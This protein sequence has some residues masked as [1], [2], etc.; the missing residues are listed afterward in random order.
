MAMI[1]SLV[2]SNGGISAWLAVAA[3]RE[4]GRRG[5]SGQRVVVEELSGRGK[6][7]EAGAAAV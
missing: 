5:V 4:A 6:M 1:E 3:A 2:A 7:E